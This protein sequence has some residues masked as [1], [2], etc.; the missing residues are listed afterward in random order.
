[1]NRLDKKDGFSE[2]KEKYNLFRGLLLWDISTDYSPRYWKV[3]NELNQVNK[4]LE[5]TNQ[6][7]QS[8]KQ[9]SKDAPRAFSGFKNRIAINEDKLN[10]LLKKVTRILSFQE[11]QIE[12]Q[13]LTSLQQ[14]YHQIENYHIRAKYSLARLY[15]RLTLPENIKNNTG[16]N[17]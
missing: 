5:I 16:S 8:L 9:S 13:A 10:T 4:L 11:K 2:E 15:D 14:R 17:K 3:K 1:M 7:L 6:R 12:N